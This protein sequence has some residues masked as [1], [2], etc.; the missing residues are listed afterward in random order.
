VQVIPAVDVLN[1]AVVRLLQGDYDAITTYG[2]DPI[3]V[4]SSWI[5]D[6]ASMVHVVDLSGA[7]T[8]DP[9][10]QLWR[11]LAGAG[12]MFQIGG[13][14]RSA[15][16][17]L[18]ALEAGAERVVVGSAAVHSSRILSEIVDAAGPDRVVVAIDVRS[19]RA[20]GS[21]WEDHG[22]ALDVVVHRVV[23]A[24]VEMALVTGIEHDGAMD[25]P[26]IDLLTEV[27]TMAP[28]LELIASGGVGSLGDI[29]VLRERC[30]NAVV[31]GRA[32]YEGRFSL[33]EAIDAAGS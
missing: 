17:A 9:N 15:E 2:A 7:R 28:D 13:G 22:V 21:G 29:A 20:R 6:G 4:A 10:R 31:V 8:G 11:S 24:G 27:Q 16:S 14:I 1:G 3:R 33:S 12:V 23:A 30:C 25:G 19:G 18:A 5:D 26:N 32:L